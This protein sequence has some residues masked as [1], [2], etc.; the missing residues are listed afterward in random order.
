MTKGRLVPV[1]NER[2]GKNTNFIIRKAKTIV[3]KKEDQLSFFKNSITTEKNLFF[4]PIN[5]KEKTTL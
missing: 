1:S 2:R 5:P 3:I 4:L